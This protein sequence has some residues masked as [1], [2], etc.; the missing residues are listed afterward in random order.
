MELATP[1]TGHMNV[2]SRVTSIHTLVVRLRGNGRNKN[3]VASHRRNNKTASLITDSL[4]AT[5]NF[6]STCHFNHRICPKQSILI[7]ARQLE[8]ARAIPLLGVDDQLAG[9]K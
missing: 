7:R 2:G 6:W 9:G 1:W 8:K 4:S 3:D 5:C